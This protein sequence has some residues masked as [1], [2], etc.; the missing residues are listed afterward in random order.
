MPGPGSGFSSA[1]NGEDGRV[2]ARG[3]TAGRVLKEP[4]LWQG[5]ETELE[6]RGML[7]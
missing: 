4:M 6:W 3:V 2:A 1:G 5:G 7:Q